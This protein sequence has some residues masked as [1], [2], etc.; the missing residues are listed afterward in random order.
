[1]YAKNLQVKWK[2]QLSPIFPDKHFH[3]AIMQW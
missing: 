1:M 3:I 2:L